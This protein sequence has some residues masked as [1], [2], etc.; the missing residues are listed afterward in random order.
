LGE[1]EE[2]MAKLKK[3]H[4]GTRFQGGGLD[5]SK[6][7]ISVEGKKGPKNAIVRPGNG[8][9]KTPAGEYDR[10][11]LGGDVLVVEAKKKSGRT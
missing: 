9:K 2:D 1:E 10:V 3:A 7:S 4:G 11:E 8:P 6:D 5:I